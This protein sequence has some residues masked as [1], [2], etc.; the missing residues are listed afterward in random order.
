MHRYK[1]CGYSYEN[2]QRAILTHS[3]KFSEME[4]ESKVL[5]SVPLA[6]KLK[7]EREGVT[8]STHTLEDVFDEIVEVMCARYGFTN[9]TEYAAVAGWFSWADLA[10]DQWDAERDD[11]TKKILEVTR[12]YGFPPEFFREIWEARYYDIEDPSRRAGLIAGT[13]FRFN[14]MVGYRLFQSA[15]DP[16]VSEESSVPHE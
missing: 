15:D 13:A 9:E 6:I 7:C 4:F 14:E 1:L 16:Y 10:G 2:T 3:E 11:F 8:T 5:M 12:Q